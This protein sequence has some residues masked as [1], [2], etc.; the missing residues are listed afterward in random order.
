[1]KPLAGFACLSLLTPAEA[2]S[3]DPFEIQ[4]YEYPTVPPRRWN[5]ETHFNYI[6]RG[7]SS[8]EGSVAPSDNQTHLTFELTRGLTPVLELAGYLVLAHTPDLGA[9]FAG[10]RL[11]PRIRAPERWGLPVGL[12]LSLEVGF[13]EPAFEENSATLEVRPIIEKVM[14][15]WQVNLNPTVGRALSGPGTS[16]GW[17]FEPSGRLGFTASSKLDLSVEYYGSLGPP[18]DFL[19][20]EEQVHQFF[21][22][23]D[24]TLTENIVWNLGLG[25]M[26]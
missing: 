3:Q 13:P 14:G 2:W 8:L 4:V 20:S 22:G 12:S 15:R 11:R 7:T 18:T 16:E 5:L 24:L 9:E 10:W 19:P 21:L 26:F 23:G 17:D 25:W 1:V 6:A